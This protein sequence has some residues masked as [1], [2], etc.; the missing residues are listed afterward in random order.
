M[1]EGGLQ[2][3]IS[4]FHR[5]VWQVFAILSVVS[6]LGFALHL[7]RP[8]LSDMLEALIHA[9]MPVGLTVIAVTGGSAFVVRRFLRAVYGSIEMSVSLLLGAIFMHD[10][11]DV[12]HQ[13]FGS[14]DPKDALKSLLCAAVYLFVRGADNLEVGLFDKD[15]KKRDRLWLWFRRRYVVRSDAA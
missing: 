5:R 15:E 10:H 4:A 9:P 3:S 6:F 11:Y 1:L 12:S 13:A 7:A 14:I 2:R 8:Y